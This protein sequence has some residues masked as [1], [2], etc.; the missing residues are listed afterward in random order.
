[1]SRYCGGAG[2]CPSERIDC[3]E[4]ESSGCSHFRKFRPHRSEEENGHTSLR[5][6]WM[7]RIKEGAMWHVRWKTE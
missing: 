6:I 1:M 5:L 7:N 4:L 2:H 3:P